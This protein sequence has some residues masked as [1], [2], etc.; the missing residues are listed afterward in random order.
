MKRTL[1]ALVVVLAIALLPVITFAAD[2]TAPVKVA[3]AT[4]EVKKVAV[5]EGDVITAGPLGATLV[6]KE[7]AVEKTAV[8][9][10]A[11]TFIVPKG[12]TEI[13]VTKGAIVEAKVEVK[14]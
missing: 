4:T 7:G 14:K 12:V 8:V 1:I 13:S 5:K 3:A 10:M 11:K 6:Y 9:E 2:M